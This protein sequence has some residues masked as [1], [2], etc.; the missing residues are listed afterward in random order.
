MWAYSAFIIVV[1]SVPS[2]FTP[3][4]SPRCWLSFSLAHCKPAL[5]DLRAVTSSQI[6]CWGWYRCVS[7]ILDCL[8]IK[9]LLSLF[10]LAPVFLSQALHLCFPHQ[11]SLYC[12]F[13]SLWALAQGCLS[14]FL[15][16]LVFL[17]PRCLVWFWRLLWLRTLSV[18]SL[19]QIAG[20]RSK[21]VH[22]QGN[23]YMQQHFK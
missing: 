19:M 11:G 12:P 8:F 4:R 9:S 22:D 14:A 15:H 13:S 1:L 6:L 18:S 7:M 10:K 2:T 16:L 3:V 17:L 20:I 5:S 23:G 21:A